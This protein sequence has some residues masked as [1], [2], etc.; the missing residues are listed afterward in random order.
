MKNLT[1][2]KGFSL[3]FIFCCVVYTVV[4]W[5]TLSQGE[6]WGVV[7]MMPLILSGF[8]GLI[9]DFI[10]IKLVRNKRILNAIELVIVL[11]FSITLWQELYP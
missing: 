3:L 7:F 9:L 4:K 5:K 10:L 8:I 2:L 11:I 6:G 1:I